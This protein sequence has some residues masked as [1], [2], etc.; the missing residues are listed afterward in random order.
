MSPISSSTVSGGRMRRSPAGTRVTWALL[1]GTVAGVI[2]SLLTPISASILLG[3]DVA[4]LIYLPWTWSAV[5]GLDPKVTAQLAK[6]EDPRTPVADLV[7]IGAGTAMLAAVGFALARA[8]EA[9]GG[10]KAYL[11]TLGL[12]SVVLSWAVVHTV[13]ALKYARAYYSEP[14]G[15][16]EFNEDE[17]PNYID[18]AYY[19]FTI[20][21]T[22]QVADT[23]ITSRA[24]RRTTL[25]H[26]LLSY[27][28]GSVLLGLVIN[29]VA[30]LLK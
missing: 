7:V 8:G 27:L 10:M 4:V 21:M 20:G 17:P 26:A 5:Q 29:V 28:F 22:F 16:I 18:F 19:A 12:V 15:G 11:V 24:V 14:A 23:N 25:H 9:T 30:T 1:G 6:R 13:F 3:W 2:A